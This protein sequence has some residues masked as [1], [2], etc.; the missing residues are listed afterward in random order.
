MSIGLAAGNFA[1]PG[2]MILAN[3]VFVPS[4]FW[5]D[6]VFDRRAAAAARGAS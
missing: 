5:K 4:W 6:F 1:L 3:L 2:T